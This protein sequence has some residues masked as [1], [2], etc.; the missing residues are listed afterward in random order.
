MDALIQKEY[1]HLKALY[2]HLHAHPELSLHEEKTSGRMA[3]ELEKIGLKV[4]RRLGGHGVVALLENGEGPAVMVRADMDALPLKEET[5]LPYASQEPGVMHACGHDVHMTCLVGTANVLS[6]IKNDWKG[7]IIFIAQPAEEKGEGAGAMIRDGLFTR[8]PKPDFALAL[9]VDSQLA[10]GKIGYGTGY[11]FANVD[12]VDLVIYGRGTHGAYPHLGIDPIVMASEIVLALQTIVSRELKPYEPAVVTVGSI[13]GGTKHNII[14]DQVKLELTVRSYG[15]EVR[16]QILE[17]IKRLAVQI[18]RAHRAPR[19]PE[20]EVTESIPSTYN[21]PN[22]VKRL[23]PVFERTVGESNAVVK[24]PEMG[25][26][27]FGLYGR[28]GVPSFMFRIGSVAKPYCSLHSSVYA[29][30]PEPTLTMG[31]RVMTA[32]L[33]ELLKSSP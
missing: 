18:A 4:T 1:P 28:A 23:V 19:E 7:K 32:L 8:F 20:F 33:L 16:N 15:E 22:L 24:E 5:G 10:V 27:D 9:H 13:H 11:A 21:D 3:E 6:Q 31:V 2:E 29:P 12:S 26:E 17:A 25:G 30:L 14:P